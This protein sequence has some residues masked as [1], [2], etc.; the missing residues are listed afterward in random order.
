M[1]FATSGAFT[2]GYLN[3]CLIVDITESI[4]LIILFHQLII[5]MYIYYA[6]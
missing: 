4:A 1:H 5:V 3:D 2:P 6:H